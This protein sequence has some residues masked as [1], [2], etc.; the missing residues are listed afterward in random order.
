[1]TVA[2]TGALLLLFGSLKVFLWI[3]ERLVT[4]QLYYEST[5]VAAGS[6]N[7]GDG[8]IWDDPAQGIRLKIFE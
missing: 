1:M 3:N 4:R 5:R 7:P 6:I 2:L 8:P